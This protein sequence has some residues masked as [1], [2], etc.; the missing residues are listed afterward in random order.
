[1]YLYIT[2]FFLQNLSKLETFFIFF[3]KK[4]RLSPIDIDIIPIYMIKTLLEAQG[5]KVDLGGYYKLDD[6]K[7]NAIMRGSATFNGILA[8]IK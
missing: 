4:N 8:K 5:K 1:M 6:T 2:T 3:Y 7:C